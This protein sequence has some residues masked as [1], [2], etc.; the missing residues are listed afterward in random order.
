MAFTPRFISAAERRPFVDR[1][2]PLE[3]F[4]RRVAAISE[5]SGPVVLNLSGI[6]GIGKSRLLSEFSKSLPESIPQATLDLQAPSLRQVD[7]ALGG[8]RKQLARHRINFARFDIAYSVYWQRFNPHLELSR[9]ELPFIEQSQIL[10]EIADSAV[11]LPLFATASS[12]VRLVSRA[13][14]STRRWATVREDSYLAGLDELPA[15]NLGDAL[16]YFF[17]HDIDQHARETSRG[18]VLFID[19]HEA[20][21]S[22]NSHRADAD[23]W[24]RDLA[25]QL[26][27]GVCVIAGREALRWEIA[28]PAWAEHLTSVPVSD[29][30]PEASDELLLAS[31]VDVVEVRRKLTASSRGLPFYLQL[32]ADT[33]DGS[34]SR[35][36]GP[37][38][39]QSLAGLL[40]KLL[41]NVERQEVDLLRL[42][43]PLRRFDRQVVSAVA[44][45]FRLPNHDGIWDSLTNYSFVLQEP[46]GYRLHDL[47]RD[48]LRERISAAEAQRVD[49]AAFRLWR[50]RLSSE[51]TV[52]AA[53][54]A[55][56]HGI[57]S[58]AIRPADVHAV[59]DLLGAAGLS[60]S[61]IDLGAEFMA[62]PGL[63]PEIS[64]ALIALTA[65]SLLNLTRISDLLVLLDACP[66]VDSRSTTERLDLVRGHALRITGRTVESMEIFGRLWEGATNS[67]VRSAA[68]LWLGD[69]HMVQG[70][71]LQAATIAQEIAA[72]ADASR[73]D[74]G[75]A[76]RLM[77]L[78]DKFRFDFPSAQANLERA[79]ALFHE[80]GDSVGLGLIE[81]NEIEVLAWLHPEHA[82]ER[83][84]RVLE[85]YIQDVPAEIGKAHTAAAQASLLSGDAV[86]AESLCRTAAVHLER[87]HYRS[88]AAR[89]LM[90]W[91][92]AAAA[93][94]ND[95]QAIETTRRG[96]SELDGVEVYPTLAVLAAAVF[97]LLGVEDDE[98]RSAGERALRRVDDGGI[99][100]FVDRCEAA[101]RALADGVASCR[102]NRGDS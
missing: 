100:Q 51:R 11:G 77:C 40:E 82:L 43:S 30:P 57:A 28:D 4:R 96:L 50:R 19:T 8:L 14:S 62:T 52:P 10:S 6:G 7:T 23:G 74:R 86:R 12:L 70:R 89:N 29:L 39:P 37:A 49:M 91:G 16:S 71:F 20:L 66:R 47:M 95:A 68:G 35:V 90:T 32:V 24:L 46:H 81:V 22:T 67:T 88:G 45:E 75:N 58:K 5:Q 54:E 93:Q 13:F 76:A 21:T 72:D 9:K 18:Y 99:L 55:L 61:L 63:D 25:Q 69:I 17:A 79:R 36:A 92:L 80:G 27:G 87:A 41:R 3:E 56:F 42:L 26:T 78:A 2:E 59:G 53:G 44:D 97:R 31:G 65:Q 84:R 60:S 98:V 83:H 101:A 38:A 64:G 1:L 85:T 73:S 34:D 15:E 48:A 102:T 33:W 94:G